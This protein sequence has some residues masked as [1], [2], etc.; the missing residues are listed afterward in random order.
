MSKSVSRLIAS[1]MLM[2]ALTA[3]GGGGDS[4]VAPEP[5]DE[6]ISTTVTGFPHLVDVYK[7]VGATRVIVMLH[8]GGGNKSAAAYQLGLNS[9]ASSTSANTVN[10][11]WLRANKVMLVLPQGQNIASE[12]NAQT[13]TNRAMNSGQD[14][15]AFLVGLAAKLRADYSLND[16]TLMG[17]SMGGAMTN[18]MWCESPA[19][20]NAYVA[21]A[22]PASSDFLAPTGTPCTPTTVRPYMGIIGDSDAIMRT[23]GAW[24]DTTWTINP[25]VVLAALNAWDNEVVISEWHQQRSR[26]SLMCGTPPEIDV[27]VT[28]GNVDTWTSCSSRLVLKRIKGADHGIESIDAQMGNSSTMDVMT[29][30]MSFLQ[31][32]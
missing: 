25:A 11:D 9:S 10:W 7:P 13:W 31:G 3:C 23:S 27:L 32:L 21:L 14:D 4:S 18:R 16:I 15:V 5:V 12:P 2:G 19:T 6:L 20:F 26:A 29:S 8:G 22:G 17:H 30:V 28:S 1:L 24:E